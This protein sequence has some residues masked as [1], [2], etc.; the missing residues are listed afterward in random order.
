M[1]PRL[2]GRGLAYST[3]YREHLL[4]VPAIRMSAFGGAPLH[5]LDWLHSHGMPSA[6]P[7]LF[8]SRKLYGAYI[9]DL[10]ETT[11]RSADPNSRR[12]HHLTQATRVILDGLIS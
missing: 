10:L 12:R 11:V 8:E 9:Q 2:L 4:N 7:G 6:D 5:F 1:E 3:S